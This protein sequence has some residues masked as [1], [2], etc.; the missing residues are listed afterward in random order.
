MTKKSHAI[1]VS[2]R[3]V[4]RGYVCEAVEAGAGA[5]LPEWCGEVGVSSPG[6]YVCRSEDG[7]VFTMS[8]ESFEK[9]YVKL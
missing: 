1:S 9:S 3:Y 2:G 8:K 7:K 6:A 4:R 5:L